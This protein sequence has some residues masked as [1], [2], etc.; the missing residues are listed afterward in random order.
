[1]LPL[2]DRFF[3]CLLGLVIWQIE[4]FLLQI[5]I[6]TK[7]NFPS[8]HDFMSDEDKNKD[9]LASCEGIVKFGH[10]LLV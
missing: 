8:R 10:T 3:N 4:I 2:F 7:S 6:A 5:S 9:S 1:M